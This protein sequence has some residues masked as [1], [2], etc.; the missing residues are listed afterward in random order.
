MTDIAH[1]PAIQNLSHMANKME[2]R[3]VATLRTVLASKNASTVFSVLFFGLFGLL[4]GFGMMPKPTGIF[5]KLLGYVLS[6]HV[7]NTSNLAWIRLYSNFYLI[8]GLVNWFN[9]A[10]VVSRNQLTLTAISNFIW[11]IHILTEFYSYKSIQFPFLIG[12]GGLFL[13]N[14][15]WNYFGVHKGPVHPSV[16]ASGNVNRAAQGTAGSY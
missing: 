15:G 8:L 16:A 7:L 4:F 14:Y 3:F 13:A 11:C 12:L 9:I 2:N 1:N 6:M 5:S 10:P